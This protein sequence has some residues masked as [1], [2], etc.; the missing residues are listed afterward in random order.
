MHIPELSESAKHDDGFT[1]GEV[2]GFLATSDQYGLTNA[3]ANDRCFVALKAQLISRDGLSEQESEMHLAWMNVNKHRFLPIFTG[4]PELL[5]WDSTARPM[6]A[7]PREVATMVLAEG[8]DALLVNA[9][10]LLNRA[11]LHALALG[12]QYL[13]LHQNQEFLTFL[14]AQ[15]PK[16]VQ[17]TLEPAADLD[18]LLTLRSAEFSSP[19]LAALGQELFRRVAAD[20]YWSVQV[21]RGLDIQV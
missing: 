12:K 10:L 14:Q 18:G 5:E 9:H 13:P 2:A 3:L 17:I 20:A 7:D 21:E 11:A 6:R 1:R 15:F 4:V 19:Q 8:A 16:S